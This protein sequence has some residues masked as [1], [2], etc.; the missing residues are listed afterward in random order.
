MFITHI[1][2]CNGKMIILYL[3]WLTDCINKHSARHRWIEKTARTAIE[4]VSKNNRY[5]REREKTTI[6]KA[7]TQEFNMCT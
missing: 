6:D 5:K 1:R 3:L 2:E 4:L 7:P